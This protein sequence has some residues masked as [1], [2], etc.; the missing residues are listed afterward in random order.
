MCGQ[1]QIQILACAGGT[2]EV[3]KRLRAAQTRAAE[4]AGQ[5]EAILLVRRSKRNAAGL[6]STA[7]A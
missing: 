7:V 5:L 1:I 2:W 6:L 4:F 3:S